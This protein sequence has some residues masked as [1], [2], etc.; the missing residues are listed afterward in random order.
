MKFLMTTEPGGQSHTVMVRDI[1]G[2]QF[3]TLA[4]RI[5]T[6]ALRFLPRFLKVC[7]YG[8]YRR[9]QLLYPMYSTKY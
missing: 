3:G 2:I 5:D 6:T 8:M 7:S 4:D 1:P 9:S